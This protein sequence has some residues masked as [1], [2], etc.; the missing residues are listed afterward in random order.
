MHLLKRIIARLNVLRIRV[1]RDSGSLR[2]TLALQKRPFS[3]SMQAPSKDTPFEAFDGIK[4]NV[5]G[6]KGG[7]PSVPGWSIVDLRDNADIQMDITHERLPFDNDSVDV[8]FTSHTLEHIYP[9]KLDVVLDEFHRVLKSGKSVL[10]ILVPDLELA[11]KA[12]AQ[13]DEQFFLDGS[14]GLDYKDVPIAGLL[15]SWLYSTRIFKDPDGKAGIG[16]VHCFDAEYM[17]FR[18]RR[19]GFRKVWKSKYRGSALPELRSDAFDRHPHDSLCIE[20][21][22]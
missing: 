10:R 7:H 19:S 2:L 20:A 1:T 3:R 12:Y 17:M 14:V 11:I 6:A 15:A 21:V 18:L 5:G 16:H 22:K 9:Q 4:L 8:I 13:R